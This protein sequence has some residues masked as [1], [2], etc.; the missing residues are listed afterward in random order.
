MRAFTG[1]RF[2]LAIAMPLILASLGAINLSY[3]L[4]NRVASAGNE[5]EHARNKKV[6]EEALNESKV[7]LDRLVLQNAKWNEAAN[8]TKDKIDPKW[9]ADT[10]GGLDGTRQ[11]YDMVAVLD[12]T[13][14]VIAGKA[15]GRELDQSFIVTENDTAVPLAELLPKNWNGRES[16]AGFASTPY[17]PAVVAFA[18]IVEPAENNRPN[19]R[20]LFMGHQLTRDALQGIEKQLLVG[21]LALAAGGVD[22]HRPAGD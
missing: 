8:Q 16:M 19:G 5:A 4:L 2:M 20:V 7:R 9:F 11:G 12:S 18:P 14:N 3:D 10:W 15:K 22:F 1:W 13:G 21:G 17:G 6:L